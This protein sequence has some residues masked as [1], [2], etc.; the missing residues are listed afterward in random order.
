MPIKPNISIIVFSLIAVLIIGGGLYGLA[1]LSRENQDILS[2][3]FIV[4]DREKKIEALE[5]DILKVGKSAE[6]ISGFAIAKDEIS[7][8]I[9]NLEMTAEKNGLEVNSQ[10]DEKVYAGP[11]GGEASPPAQAGETSFLVLNLILHGSP[12]N[13]KNFLNEIERYPKF[14]NIRKATY[15]FF[16]D[17]RERLQLEIIIFIE[18]NA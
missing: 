6:I 10:L 3:I 17:G 2:R 1:V 14:I 15:N 8:L 13:L 7:E 18:T 12:A 4:E 16:E 5:R 9:D 11:P